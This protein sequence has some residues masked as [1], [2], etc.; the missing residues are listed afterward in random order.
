MAK[1]AEQYPAADAIF[2]RGRS[3]D[4]VVALGADVVK[5]PNVIGLD[6]PAAELL[7][8]AKDLVMQASGQYSATIPA[9]AV[10]SQDPAAGTKVRVK[11]QVQ[12]VVSLGI[13]PELGSGSESSAG[14]GSSSSGGSGTSADDAPGSNCTASYPNA[15]VWASGGDIYIRLT[16]GSGSRRL[17]SGS[18]WDSGPILAPSAKYVVFMRAPSSGKSPN[19][20]GRVCLTNFAV[21][22]LKMPATPPLSP[23]TVTYGSPRFA[24]SPTGTAPDSDWIVTP[25]YPSDGSHAI[26]GGPGRLL[27]TNVPAG[28]TW[29]SKNV[30]FTPTPGTKLSRSSKAGCVKVTASRAVGCATSTSTPAC[31]R[32]SSE[33]ALRPHSAQ[34]KIGVDGKVV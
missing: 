6:T 26:A 7:L 24:P 25:Q 15:E 10:M 2:A 29:V 20:I 17:T 31:T 18:A 3:V 19:G 22:M 8:S 27:V 11:S 34:H 16:P 21:T 9:G 32:A 1:V 33:S 4:L 12:V 30:L 5:V 13:E 28:S 23:Q 14:S